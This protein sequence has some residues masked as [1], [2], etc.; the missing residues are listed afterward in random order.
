MT[1]TSFITSPKAAAATLIY[2]CQLL[3]ETSTGV[4]ASSL[5][6]LTLSLVDSISFAVI[7]SVS[8]ISVLNTGRGTVDSSG[9]VVITLNATD[10]ALQSSLSSQE[11]RSLIIDFTYS[12]G[13][14]GRHQVDILLVALSGS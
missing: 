1:R 2:K 9:N 14:V 4:P 7:N 11:F 12:G 6:A 5:S 13:K 10:T 3:D 8:Q